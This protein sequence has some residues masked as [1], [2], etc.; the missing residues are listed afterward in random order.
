MCVFVKF[1]SNVI[2]VAHGDYGLYRISRSKMDKEVNS[3]LS[4][5]HI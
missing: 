1:I 3:M 5:I 2:F 4:L